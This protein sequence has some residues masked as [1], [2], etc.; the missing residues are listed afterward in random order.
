VHLREGGKLLG[1]GQGQA[2]GSGLSAVEL[3]PDAEA[4]DGSDA[5]LVL[6][7]TVPLPGPT[8]EGPSPPVLLPLVRPVGLSGGAAR[9]RLW[10][11]PGL[12]CKAASG[13][14]E[15]AASELVPERDALPNLVLRG[16]LETPLTLRFEAAASPVAS[17][18]VDRMLV[19]ASVSPAS[20]PGFRLRFLVSKVHARRLDLLLP[21]TRA[22]ASLDVRLDGK[23][24]PMRAPDESTPTDPSGRLVSF[25]VDPELYRGP[26]VL[27]VSYQPVQGTADVQA[28]RQTSLQ[29]PQL[30]GAVLLGRARWLV[31][32]PTGWL[33]L[34]SGS[35]LTPELRWGRRGWLPAPLP[36]ATAAELETW[37]AGT[38]SVPSPEGGPGSWV[39]WASHQTT[40]DVVFVP[41]QAWLLL[42]SLAV[43]GAGVLLTLT[44]LPRWAFWPLVA[45]VVG[46]FV[47]LAVGAP[48]LLPVV[49]SGAL[50]GLAV[51]LLLLALHGVLL[52]R[53][54]RRLAFLPSFARKA[55][56]SLIR[57]ESSSRRKA[58]PPREPSTAD[59]PARRGSSSGV[60]LH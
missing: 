13:S 8:S 44:P 41:F 27:E 58:V 60:E 14:W 24:L 4:D 22:R 30:R 46:G 7:Y 10:T 21:V 43:L 39:G 33:P 53:S 37:L 15:E 47:I 32:G 45:L 20:P 18:V 5:P 40:L 52:R 3:T 55:G 36:E 50:P 9:I 11:E 6:E 38:G 25:R 26:V 19:H 54:R 51:L 57:S 1:V 59:E 12:H 42:C 17:V 31:E 16:R 48:D 35:T 2:L 29:P 34:C 56:S 23:R 49:A 28:W